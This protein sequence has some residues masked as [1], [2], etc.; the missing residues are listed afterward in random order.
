MKILQQSHSS[1]LHGALV[2]KL[3]PKRF[4]RMSELMAAVVGFVL[5]TR[6]SQPSIAE[7]VVTSDGFLLARAEDEVGANHFIGSHADLTRNW[8]ALIAVA[9]L[10]TSEWIEATALFAAKIGYSGREVA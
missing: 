10:T 6:F 8:L 1:H 3:N 7:I 2:Q 5:D 9:G 4:P